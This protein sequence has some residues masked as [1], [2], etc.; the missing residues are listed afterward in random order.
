MFQWALLPVVEPYHRKDYFSRFYAKVTGLSLHP[1]YQTAETMLNMTTKVPISAKVASQMLSAS[2]NPAR[3]FTLSSL[4][5]AEATKDWEGRQPEE[6]VANQDHH[7]DIHASASVEGRKERSTGS[8]GE[9]ASSEK[10]HKLGNQKAKEDHPEAPGP[11]IGMNDE[12]GGVSIFNPFLLEADMLMI[13]Q[14]G[15]DGKSV[16]S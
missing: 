3:P 6:H 14:K 5:Y 8:R 12:R 10:D 4:Y 15:H 13:R 1:S 2:R 16:G 7:I 9:S 11:V